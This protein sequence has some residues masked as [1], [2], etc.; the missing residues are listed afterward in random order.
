MMRVPLSAYKSNSYTIADNKGAFTEY[1]HLVVDQLLVVRRL[2]G[3]GHLAA[4]HGQS[5]N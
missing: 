4:V 3:N 5:Y 1:S 2:T